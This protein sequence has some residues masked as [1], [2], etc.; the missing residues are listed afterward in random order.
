MILF[1]QLKYIVGLCFPK[2][3]R[4]ISWRDVYVS[5]ATCP[6]GDGYDECYG[7]NFQGKSNDDM[8][9]LK[10][11]MG[12]ILAEGTVKNH[13]DIHVQAMRKGPFDTEVLIVVSLRRHST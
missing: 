13:P 1:K 11:K 7:L 12:R 8:I 4:K 9:L 3:P 5:S 10:D 6:I 2:E